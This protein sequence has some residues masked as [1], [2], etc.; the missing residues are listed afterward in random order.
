MYHLVQL[1]GN[2]SPVVYFQSGPGELFPSVSK[3]QD[4]LPKSWRTFI[5]KDTRTKEANYPYLQRVPQPGREA[6]LLVHKDQESLAGPCYFPMPARLELQNRYL[7]SLFV[8]PMLDG[9]R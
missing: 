1:E 8:A 4:T 2:G 7:S 9:L 6:L 5:V 3:N